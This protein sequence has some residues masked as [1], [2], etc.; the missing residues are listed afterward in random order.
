MASAIERRLAAILAMDVV[1]YSRL[2]GA[3]EIGTLNAL[4]R[5]RAE[6]IDPATA[7]HS[8]RLVKTTGDGLLL[9]F[10]SVVD[11][12]GC[13]VAIQR[14]MLTRN[15]TVPEA[16]RIVFR[17]GVNIGD[18][19]IEGNDIFGDGVN[20]AARLEALCEPGGVCISR[21]ANEQVRDKLSLS[22]ADLGEHTVKNIARAIGVFGL[23]AKDIASLPEIP[24]ARLEPTAGGAARNMR[25][26]AIAAGV[27]AVVLIG[28]A[29]W[30][31]TR[32]GPPTPPQPLDVRLAAAL[33]RNIPDAAAKY[34]DEVTVGFV[35]MT[36]NRAMALALQTNGSFRTGEWPTREIA[37]EKALEKCQAQHNEPCA[38]VAVNDDVI[39]P[40]GGSSLPTRDAAR[41]RYA[42]LY[43]AERIPGIRPRDALRPDV[44]AYA[45]A[46]G[47]RA[48]AFHPIGIV[49]TV[50][51][52]P[53]QRAAEEQALAAC[54]KDPS[55]RDAGGLCFLYAVENRVVL[56][57]R[58]TAPM[59][60]APATAAAAPAPSAEAALRL[61]LL[62]RM[63]K[64]V[65][66]HNVTNRD[67]QIDGYLKATAQK[68]I[69]AFPP[70]YTWRVHGWGTAALAE[71]RS[72]EACQVR[73]GEPCVLLAV[74]DAVQP[75]PA[76]G[77]WPRR[78]M[79]RVAYGGLFDPEQIPAVNTALRQRA[80]V[81]AYRDKPGPKA[82][83]F[84]PWGRLFVVIDAAN[85]RAA[86]E[87]ALATCS[88]DPD[89][90]GESGPCLL[91]AVGN[92][93][94]LP[95]RSLT[96]LTN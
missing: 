8:G 36:A 48:V 41:V 60:A 40:A 4:K 94:V 64:V 54:N 43:N 20:V 42:G 26:A 95:K 51:A 79:T 88:S 74:N 69:A 35:K 12:I 65:P 27:A 11:A 55:R 73:H 6:L 24:V 46:T 57:L 32:E 75:V 70:T 23:A 13:A 92:Q 28:G 62:D 10:A 84:H 90:K 83:A 96:P 25:P 86:E 77:N 9:E 38:I 15:E 72:L 63:T 29:A 71:E 49:H 52:A 66:S 1:G 59:T 82:A 21:S 61:A 31:F 18:I 16:R 93:V 22:F 87:L 17:I 50:T 67:V 58:V 3:D 34:R 37:E 76:D 39:S 45:T 81:A 2:M 85:Q 47:P 53:N 56:P 33:A 78:P 80:D 44:Q 68:A 30:W 89:R 91:Y 5:H 19:I 14:G 7:A